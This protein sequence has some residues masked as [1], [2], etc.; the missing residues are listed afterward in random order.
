MFFP[1]MSK[2]NEIFFEFVVFYTV[3]II[4]IKSLWYFYFVLK[5]KI[6]KYISLFTFSFFSI[7]VVASDDGNL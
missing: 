4:L 7:E 3:F 1:N 2:Q 5:K 6:K